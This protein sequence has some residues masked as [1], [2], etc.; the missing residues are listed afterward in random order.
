MTDAA[1]QHLDVN[2]IDIALRHRP[3]RSPG[4]VWLGG[5]R[6]DMMGTKAE[7]LDA[8]AGEN[9]YA[10]LRHDYS[11][12][13]ESGGDFADGT[14]SRWLEQSLAIFRRFSEGPQ[15]LV[16]SSM[17]A[18]I[19][20]RIV[21]ELQ[22][23]GEGDRVGALLLLAPAPDF[24]VELMEPELTDAHRRDLE[25]KGYME[26]PSEYSPEPNIY[27]RALFEDGRA[28]RVLDGIID[29]HCPVTIIQ[30]L[31]DPDVPHTH[32]LKL[33]EHLPADDVTL[34]LVR[35]GDH[36]LSR[37]QDIALIVKAAQGLVERISA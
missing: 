4:L 13:G 22:K 26:E 34:S 2:G 16:G 33:V 27:T 14:I 31:A 17:G 29:T 36:R 15:I 18:W 11:G 32:A 8:W 12:H 19:A 23:A 9:G 21:Q 10:F 3:G 5:Y 35:D 37:P 6:S 20:L 24:T 25:T 1:P 28:N 7:A 30:G